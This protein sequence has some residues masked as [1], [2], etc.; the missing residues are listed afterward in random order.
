M[1][2]KGD[3][4]M[5]K[6]VL[7]T[8]L[9]NGDLS[10]TIRVVNGRLT[11]GKTKYAK[12][13]ITIPKEYSES[14]KRKELEEATYKFEEE[15]KKGLLIQGNTFFKE[16]SE[17]WLYT[18]KGLAP[19]TYHD[20]ENTVNRLKEE[21]GHY[22]LE[23]IKSLMLIKFFEKLRIDGS[24]KK[25]GKKGLSE[26][27]IKNIYDILYNIFECAI[28][29]EVLYRNPLKR[30]S[31]PKP[32]PVRKPIVFLDENDIV[33]LAK[34]LK[35]DNVDLKYQCMIRIALGVGARIGEIEALEW[36]DV[37][38]KTGVIKITKTIQNISG[39]G[40]VEKP[41]K[42][43]NSIREVMIGQD[44]I[45]L[46]K[47]HK[48]EQEQTKNNLGDLWQNDIEVKDAKG[49]TIIKQNDKIF[50]Q[51]DG[52]PIYNGTFGKWLKKFTKKHGLKPYT[53][54]S[55]RH[56]FATLSLEANQPI[57]AISRTLGHSNISTTTD[58]YVK[59][60]DK[61]KETLSSVMSNKM[62]D[63]FHL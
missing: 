36:S 15:I 12:R 21:F 7:K 9:K 28:D 20:Y 53:P 26:K 56:T 50:T 39:L 38:F 27:T 13:T 61:S 11:S 33:K 51:W 22:K 30:K 29:D 17:D 60:T 49:N 1:K 42:T 32:K 44:V 16:Y 2:I 54:H 23:E 58:I 57:N 63:I 45:E 43:K 4:K 5:V 25:T 10:Y 41:P 37:N 35:I 48:K 34:A 6:P 8:I 14:K 40:T 62:N 47:E 55:F 31:F 52:K 18:K 59:T 46:L 19:S 24:K 3:K